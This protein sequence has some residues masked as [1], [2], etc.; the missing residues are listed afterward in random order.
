VPARLLVLILLLACSACTTLPQ[1]RGEALESAA[2][3]PR[4]PACESEIKAFIELTKLAKEFGE[5][6]R[7][8]QPALEA[9]Q[10]QIMDCVDDNYPDPISI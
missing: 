1:R 8:Y 5:N 2:G 3:L 6:W 10:D 7:I 9:M 4:Y